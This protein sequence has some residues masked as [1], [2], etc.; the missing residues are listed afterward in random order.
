MRS[1]LTLHYASFTIAWWE[2]ERCL[3]DLYRTMLRDASYERFLTVISIR[4]G[5]SPSS[6][7]NSGPLSPP[8]WMSQNLF[9]NPSNY[10]F[11]CWEDACD[12]SQGLW[13]FIDVGSQKSRV[14]FPSRYTGK[15]G[16]D[17][18]TQGPRSC[19]VLIFP[20]NTTAI[21][22]ELPSHGSV[23][24]AIYCDIKKSAAEVQWSHLDCAFESIPP[25]PFR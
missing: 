6:V 11:Y 12:N 1:K 20:L 16:W 5:V 4:A 23:V 17:Q 2:M 7:R 25:S 10:T 14:A 19:L 24:E 18:T 8:L 13:R 9:A 15:S 21:S 3:F 22:A